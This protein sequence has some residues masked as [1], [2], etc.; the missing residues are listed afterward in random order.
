[1]KEPW[2]E[3]RQP[4]A[5]NEVGTEFYILHS[6]TAYLKENKSTGKSIKGLNNH[7]V[8]RI[9]RGDKL[10]YIITQGEGIVT[11][12]CETEEDL[13]TAIEGLRLQYARRK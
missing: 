11:F 13:L 12:E 6:E 4:D 8:L 9:R 1:M 5:I 2:D 3:G 10:R 7:L